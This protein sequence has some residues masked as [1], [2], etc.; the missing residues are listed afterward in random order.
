MRDHD[1]AKMDEHIALLRRLAAEVREREPR[2]S[3]DVDEEEQ[4]RNMGEVIDRHP[5]VIEAAEEAVRRIGVEPVHTI[6]R[7]GTD[8]AR[9]SHRGLPTPEPLHRRLRVPL[10]P[11]V[12]ERAG[13][14]RRGRDDRRAR[15]RL[16]RAL[17]LRSRIWDSR[18]R[19]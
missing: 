8:G 7:G 14:G 6:I 17:T 19:S 1:A 5:E 11:R 2:A 13:H 18:K 10:A 16:G 15:P 3:V 9:L 12:G 4:Y